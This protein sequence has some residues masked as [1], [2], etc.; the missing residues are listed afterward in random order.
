MSENL[1]QTAITLIRTGNKATGAQLLAQALRTD[2]SNC[3]AWRWMT[4]IADS[5]AKKRE[6]L[7]RVLDL[8]P[9]NVVTCL[10]S[11]D[12]PAVKNIDENL[13]RDVAFSVAWGQYRKEVWDGANEPLAVLLGTDY[14]LH[15]DTNSIRRDL[16]GEESTT[17]LE[18]P[19]PYE[20][21]TEKLPELL[22]LGKLSVAA[23][24]VFIRAMEWVEPRSG[25]V[26]YRSYSPFADR[27]GDD[28]DFQN[29]LDELASAGL[30]DLRPSISD[31][32]MNLTLKKLKQFAFEQGIPSRGSKR[33]LI[34]NI[35]AEA[36]EKAIETLLT[37]NLCAD[38]RYIRP[39]AENLRL[40]AWHVIDEWS[41]LDQYLQWVRSIHCLRLA[42]PVHPPVKHFGLNMQSR[43]QWDSAPLDGLFKTEVNLVRRVWDSQCDRLVIEL[44]DRYAWDTPWH[45]PEAIAEYLPVGEFE[46]IKKACDDFGLSTWRDL[47]MRYGRH[48]LAEMKIA[49]REPRNLRCANCG[50]DFVE[51]SITQYV[52]Q[53]VNYKI[54]FCLECYNRVLWQNRTIN[55]DDDILEARISQEEMLGQVAA[56]ATALESVPTAT[57]IRHPDLATFTEETQIAV[58][59]ILLA[60]PPYGLYVRTFGSWLRALVLAGVLEDGTQRTSRGIRCIAN[61]GH[62]CYSLAE[63]IIDDWLSSQGIPHEKEPQYPY[64]S[65]LNPFAM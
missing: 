1:A 49:F 2:P 8:E 35:L 25:F 24:K 38:A 29:A 62:E 22:S 44:A 33:Y 42:P 59:K 48:R 28:P 9:D 64:D 61:D 50:R 40:L 20:K 31:L 16:F 36:S 55:I 21:R 4:H 6:C 19:V 53:R 27:F 7:E 26:A 11:Y 41:R 39:V 65:Q 52:A 32:L 57:F 18:M 43:V 63:K 54:C 10:L 12:Y 14:I 23:R 51:S 3:L 45:I 60:M 5:L 56:L 34:G 58:V 37:A 46:R 17:K 47:F 13:R 30:I 15:V